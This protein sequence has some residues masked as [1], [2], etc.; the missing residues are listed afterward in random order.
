MDSS[1]KLA[2]SRWD[3]IASVRSSPDSY[4]LNLDSNVTKTN[5]W[6]LPGYSGILSE[7]E[8][9]GLRPHE[10]DYVMGVQMLE[11]LSKQARFEIECVNTVAQCIAF[12]R[13]PFNISQSY[14]LDALKIYT[15]EGYHSFFTKKLA[16]QIIVHFKISSLDIDSIVCSHFA[17]IAAIGK[18]F[19]DD[20]SYLANLAVVFVAENQIIG[21]L[22]EQMRSIVHKPIVSMFRDHM[23]DESFHAKYF[24][25]LLP[26]IWEQMTEVQ[27]YVFGACLCESMLVLGRPRTDIYFLSLSSLGFSHDLISKCINNKYDNDEWNTCRVRE[28]MK[29][30]LQL[31]DSVGMFNSDEIMNVFQSKGLLA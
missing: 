24:A 18:S 15:D 11:F 5:S 17:K 29:P 3:S 20:F 22:T 21:D 31:L 9:S 6:H 12:D 13:Y 23:V 16:D 10:I 14:K 1:L 25:S 7:P 27:R 4:D 30:T 28:R 2:S 19:A 8:F 26:I